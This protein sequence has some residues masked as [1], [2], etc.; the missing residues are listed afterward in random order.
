MKTEYI[1]ENCGIVASKWYGKCPQCQ[2]WNTFIEKESTVEAPLKNKAK[3]SK[4]NS[5]ITTD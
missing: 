2:E 1:C 3:H 4:V 5:N